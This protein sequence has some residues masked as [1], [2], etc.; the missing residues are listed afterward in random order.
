VKSLGLKVP[1]PVKGLLL[2]VPFIAIALAVTYQPQFPISHYYVVAAIVIIF[3]LSFSLFIAYAMAHPAQFGLPTTGEQ[4]VAAPTRRP[5]APFG[6]EP[7]EFREMMAE[8]DALVPH[9]YRDCKVNQSGT[10]ERMKVPPGGGPLIRQMTPEEKAARDAKEG[11]DGVSM[12]DMGDSYVFQLKLDHVDPE[13]LGLSAVREGLEIKTP[14]AAELPP[15]FKRCRPEDGVINLRMRT[16]D[17]IIPARSW[18]DLWTDALRVTMPKDIQRTMDGPDDKPLRPI[19]REGAAPTLPPPNEALKH[20]PDITEL[21]VDDLGDAFEV[22]VVRSP[23]SNFELSYTTDRSTLKLKTIKSV[24][25]KRPQG[26]LFVCEG[27]IIILELPE[28]VVPKASTHT[29]DGT[30]MRIL[31][32]KEQGR[33]PNN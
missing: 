10:L 9:G 16:N 14:E 27:R 3:T 21:Y 8:M 23:G 28:P 15:L 7:L 11:E 18:A 30:A 13:V 22:V 31:V 6:D 12:L 4:A 20:R 2:G 26:P 5:P 1:W 29:M 19:Q 24:F 25:H 33:L 32:R 17:R